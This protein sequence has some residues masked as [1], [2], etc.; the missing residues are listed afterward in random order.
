MEFDTYTLLT[1]LTQDRVQPIKPNYPNSN[2]I[3]LEPNQ[4]QMSLLGSRLFSRYQVNISPWMHPQ[5]VWILLNFEGNVRKWQYS[6]KSDKHLQS[7]L[8]I[9]IKLTILI[10]SI[11]EKLRTNTLTYTRDG[12]SKNEKNKTRLGYFI[13]KTVYFI[14]LVL[15]MNEWL[16]RICLTWITV[17]LGHGG[18]GGKRAT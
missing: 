11:L 2:Q 10:S 14:L 17:R 5:K 1:K 18:L 8:L 9:N 6:K 16:F 3:K 4:T 15:I 13:V 12:P 7:I